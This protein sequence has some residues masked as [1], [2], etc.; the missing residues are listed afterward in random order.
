MICTQAQWSFNI[1]L[2]PKPIFE[3]Q[4]RALAL[5]CWR[6]P[7]C[8]RCVWPMCILACKL[9]CVVAVI[10]GCTHGAYVSLFI[11]ECGCGSAGPRWEAEPRTCKV[12]PKQVLKRWA[13]YYAHVCSA[14]I[15]I[16]GNGSQYLWGQ[17]DRV[18]QENISETESYW[19]W[20]KHA[21]TLL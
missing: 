6:A 2:F 5:A 7:V 4:S 21:G 10:A 15:W 17:Y 8:L 11:N 18:H 9:S 14:G 1:D 19:E 13:F 12:H 20:V 3:D 16:Q